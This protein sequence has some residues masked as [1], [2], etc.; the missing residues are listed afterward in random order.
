MPTNKNAAAAIPEAPVGSVVFMAIGVIALVATGLYVG[1]QLGWTALRRN[2]LIAAML[3]AAL[4]V[5][6]ARERL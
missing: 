3:L 1:K 6:Y 2:F 4:T 5:W